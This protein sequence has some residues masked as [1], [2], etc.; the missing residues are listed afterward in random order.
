MGCEKKKESRS[1]GRESLIGNVKAIIYPEFQVRGFK[2][3]HFFLE[4][5]SPIIFNWHPS[6][7]SRR[8]K[9]LF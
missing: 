1:P 7:S 5:I 8:R 4:S 3:D 6:K 9:N 2:L